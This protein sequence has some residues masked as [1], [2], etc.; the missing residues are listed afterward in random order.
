[1]AIPAMSMVKPT[2]ATTNFFTWRRVLMIVFFGL[3][4]KNGVS[5]P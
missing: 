1:M 2:T 3:M 4:L 5:F